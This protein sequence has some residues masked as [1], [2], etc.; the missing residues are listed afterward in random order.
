MKIC[1]CRFLLAAAVVVLA[2][3]WWPAIWA[4]WVIVAAAAILAIMSLFFQTCCCRSMKKTE[5]GTAKTEARTKHPMHF[6]S[7]EGEIYLVFRKFP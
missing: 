4:K 2:I 3:L 1:F 5:A 6:L 7:A